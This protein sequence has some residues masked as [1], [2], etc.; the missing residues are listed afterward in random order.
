MAVELLNAQTET[1]ELAV[2]RV[3]AGPKLVLLHGGM[4]SWT[5]WI[6]NIDVL[7][8]HFHVHAVDSP[9]YGD[10]PPVDKSMNADEYKDLVLRAVDNIAGK[11]EPFSIAGFSFGGA[12]SSHIAARLGDRVRSLSI[13]GSAGFARSPNAPKRDT[14]SYKSAGDDA[15][16]YREIV[17]HNLATFMLD[18]PFDEQAVDIQA[19]NVARAGFDSRKVSGAD[20]QRHDLAKITCP[21][22]AIWGENDITAQPSVDA[23]VALCRDIV[24][25]M[26]F[27]FVPGAPHWVMYAAADE[28]NKALLDFLPRAD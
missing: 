11:N 13:C 4:G 21:F 2:K 23:R 3:G 8:E 5:H 16:L 6:K 24:P 17:R 28:V 18:E 14:R 26:R 22:Q 19:A 1:P 20:S 10:S 7:A 27:D 15:A 25:D 12:I 9:G